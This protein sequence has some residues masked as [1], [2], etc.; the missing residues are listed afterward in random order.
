MFRS[1]KQEEAAALS[2]NIRWANQ[3]RYKQGK[4][5]IA[6]R[7]FMGYDFD[8]DKGLV[9]NKEAEIV[10]RIFSEYLGGKG[11]NNMYGYATDMLKTVKF[12]AGVALWMN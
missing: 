12:I 10:K 4:Y 3:K 5:Q 11:T 7:K 6:S 2:S 1:T 9:I 8:K